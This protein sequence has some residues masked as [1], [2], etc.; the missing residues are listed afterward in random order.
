[1]KQRARLG[2]GLALSVAMWAGVSEAQ[3]PPR[4]TPVVLTGSLVGGDLFVSYC[5][6]CH[7]KG[8]KGDGP[9]AGAL[10]VPPADLTGLARRHKGTYPAAL[11]RERLNGSTGPGGSTAHGSTDMP[12]WGAIFRQLDA[13]ASVAKV[14]VDNL[15]KHLET[16]QVK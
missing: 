9:A 13:N 12:V 7:G 4:D 14:R 5:G 1:M 16:M 6:S 15:V 2:A 8:G 11:V 10:T 3:S